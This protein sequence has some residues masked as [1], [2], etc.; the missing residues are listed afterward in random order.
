[1]KK[2]FALL[3]ILAAIMLAVPFHVS[4][5]VTVK[6]FQVT[7][8]ASATQIMANTAYVRGIYFQNNAAHNMRIGDSSVTASKGILLVAGSPGGSYT[9]GPLYDSS[10]DAT[11]FYVAG[12]QNDVLDVTWIN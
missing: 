11:V 12:T 3:V 9:V 5:A 2:T 8:G 7:I 6:S 1:M 10:I 4:D